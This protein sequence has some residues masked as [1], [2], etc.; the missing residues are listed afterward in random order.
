M[1]LDLLHNFWGSIKRIFFAILLED[2]FCLPDWV[3]QNLS[4]ASLEQTGEKSHVFSNPRS[5]ARGAFCI[6]ALVSAALQADSRSP[7]DRQVQNMQHQ[8]SN[9]DQEIAAMKQ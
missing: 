6:A 2:K 9:Q 5:Y 7:L 3:C 4:S 1:M 8:M